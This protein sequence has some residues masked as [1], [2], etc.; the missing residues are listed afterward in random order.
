MI[1]TLEQ[2]KK[3][4]NVDEYFHDD[5]KY[6]LSLGEVAESAVESHI[7]CSIQHVTARNGGMCPVGLQQAMLMLAAH[8][9]NQREAVSDKSQVEIP[10]GYTYL[11]APYINYSGRG[12]E[13]DQDH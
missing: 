10:L 7:D 11:L 13:C 6:I 9:Y 8:L 1:L 4:M 12:K 3:Q 2:L 5:D